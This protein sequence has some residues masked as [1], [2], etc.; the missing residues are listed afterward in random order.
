MIFAYIIAL[1]HAITYGVRDV[2]T[3][4]ALDGYILRH[5]LSNQLGST[6]FVRFFFEHEPSVPLKPILASIPKGQ[7][8]LAHSSHR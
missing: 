7:S 2:V 8:A 3:Q 5:P 4:K 1:A 6:N